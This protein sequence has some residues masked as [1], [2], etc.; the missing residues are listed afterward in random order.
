M[1]SPLAEPLKASFLP[2]VTDL[3]GACGASIL[4]GQGFLGGPGQWLEGHGATHSGR[5]LQGQRAQKGHL[6]QGLPLSELNFRHLEW[7]RHQPH[8]QGC[9][10]LMETWLRKTPCSIGVGPTPKG[11]P[12]RWDHTG[13]DVFG[14]VC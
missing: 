6:V 13:K 12:Q 9:Q 10:G 1:D 14:M 8:V 4:L 11:K 2:L 5:R 3:T 7:G